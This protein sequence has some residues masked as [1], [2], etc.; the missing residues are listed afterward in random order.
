MYLFKAMN[1]F[2]YNPARGRFRGYLHCAVANSLT[3]RQNRH[4]R[5]EK[6]V[7]PAKLEALAKCDDALDTE[8]EREWQLHKLR[9]ALQAISPEFESQTL[10]IFR[11]HVL[12]G[13]GVEDTAAKLEVSKSSVYQAKCRVLKRLKEQIEQMDTDE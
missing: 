10:D 6:G 3:R 11:V 13:C 12:S 7:D 9:T 8:W 2:E 5:R 4:A 1:G